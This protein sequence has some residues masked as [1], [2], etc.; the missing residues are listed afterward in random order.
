[1]LRDEMGQSLDIVPPS[2]TRVLQESTDCRITLDSLHLVAGNLIAVIV[3][4][5]WV[6]L[7]YILNQ[8]GSNVFVVDEAAYARASAVNAFCG[9][10]GG[11]EA[12][13][14]GEERDVG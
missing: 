1:M 3:P 13:D 10:G 7:R 14:G 6:D 2:P 5:V 8:L 12:A 9:D 11:W 4:A